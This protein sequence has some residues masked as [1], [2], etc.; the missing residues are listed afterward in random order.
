[1]HEQLFEALRRDHQEV[2][3]LFQ[4]LQ[5]ITQ[6]S[7]RARILG[8]L[9]LEILPHMKAEEKVLYPALKEN[10]S[11]RVDALESLEEHYA[12]QSVLKELMKTPANDERFLPKARVLMEMVEHHV[13][14]EEERI[15]QDIR[16]AL[17]EEQTSE[18]L[19]R[20]NKEKEKSRRNLQ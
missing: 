9:R 4:K 11:I 2:N 10:K 16:S 6:S 15:F 7:E 20:F 12:A 19:E 13:Q 14:E 1:M 5:E 17:S 18:I 8:K 3:T